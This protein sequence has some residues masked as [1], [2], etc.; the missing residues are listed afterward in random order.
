MQYAPLS[1]DED[2]VAKLAD[3]FATYSTL[4]NVYAP[5]SGGP[6]S[7]PCCGH[8]TLTERGAYEICSECDW[9]DDGQD[10]HDADVAR[11]GPNGGMSLEDA[12]AAYVEEGGTLLPHFPP[13]E[14]S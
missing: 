7:C 11:N 10:D 8:V 9:E 6:Y 4:Q 13:A 5:A 1:I 3:W 14:P 12:R 2:V